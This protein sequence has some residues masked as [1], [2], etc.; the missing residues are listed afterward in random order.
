MAGR[1]VAAVTPVH[2]VELSASAFPYLEDHEVAD[3]VVFPGCGC[4]DAAL[5]AFAEDDPCVVEDVVFHRPLV[6]PSSSVTTLR[7]GY[8]PDRR[9][10]TMH[11][12]ANP[13]DATWTLHTE[14]RRAH[15]AN[16]RIP[17]RRPAAPDALVDG[18]PNLIHEEIYSRLTAAGLHYGPSFQVVDR[19][20]GRTD[21][22]EIFAE[23][24]LDTVEREGHRLHPARLDGALQAVIVGAHMFGE[25]T[26][27]GTY[28]PPHVESF[29]F[30]RSP[31]GRLWV[32]G[33]GKEFTKPGMVECD[34]TLVTD[35]GKVVAEIRGLR[36]TRLSEAAEQVPKL[37]YRHSW[38]AQPLEQEADGQGR[39]VVVG[40]SATATGL[41]DALSA[42][43][44]E[45]V[46]T[47]VADR[48][49]IETVV[50]VT[51]D[52]G[53]CRGVIY[54]DEISAITSPL[55][56]PAANPLQLVQGLA[57]ASGRL[58]LVTTGAQSVSAND[59]TTSPSGAAVWGF[60]RIVPAEL[61]ELRC[62]LIDLAPGGLDDKLLDALLKLYSRG[63][64]IR[65][66]AQR[67]Y[68]SW[69]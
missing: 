25:E 17:L 55:C 16:A 48:N 5:A 67:R 62:R 3:A 69:S 54:V 11:S 7:V 18:L 43:G 20:W 37:V 10:V 40:S 12:R 57:G 58:F 52:D 41:A 59:P 19:V 64:T 44:G 9:H 1:A 63:M 34:L 35:N 45:V 22:R 47:A 24:R 66:I 51:A 23:L 31:A 56:S 60:G 26:D 68:L 33:R 29:Q 2:D 8:D 15:V 49:W 65:D 4:L 27:L 61:P 42:L 53:V 13:D 46:R 28:V 21:T 50:S 38:E 39:W 36:A 32:H 6:L 30:F 14:L